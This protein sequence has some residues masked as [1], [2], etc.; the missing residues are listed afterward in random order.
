MIVSAPDSRIAGSHISLLPRRI[1]QHDSRAVSM[2]LILVKLFILFFVFGF[3][4]FPDVLQ[5]D[6]A[7]R[8]STCPGEPFA[9][10]LG[11]P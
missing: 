8:R 11:S 1:P 9:Q 4:L 2:V 5:R 7:D 10:P 6:Y 3:V